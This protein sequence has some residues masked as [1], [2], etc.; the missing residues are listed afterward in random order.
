[1]K[2]I[3]KNSKIVFIGGGGLCRDFLMALTGES[4]ADLNVTILG[5]ADL[6]G[7]APGFEYAKI[8]GIKTTTDFMELIKN[9]DADLI[10][11][12]TGN[13][14]VLE[15]ISANKHERARVIDHIEALTFQHYLLIEEK[16]VELKERLAKQ[17]KDEDKAERE[18]EIFSSELQRIIQEKIKYIYEVE[19]NLKKRTANV[20]EI[21]NDLLERVKAIY[22]EEKEKYNILFDTDP[23]PI[24]IID[25]NTFKILD[26]NKRAQAYYGFSKEELLKMSFL[27]LGEDR[28]TELMDRLKDI[29]ED[30]C[31]FFSKKKHYRKDRH[32][33]YVNINVCHS[34]YLEDEAFI[35]TTTDISE[36]TEK[37]IQLIQTS[38]MTTLGTMAAGIAH[39][40]T[41]PLN[42][43][44]VGADFF[45]KKIRKGEDIDKED[46][47]TMANEINASV[48]RA[49]EI[50][51]QMRN[52][53]RQSDTGGV[54]TN[55]NTPIRDV[56]RLLRQ[57][58]RVH[59]IE[60]ELD[61]DENIP[62]IIADHNRMVQVF[63][64]L[65]INA[66]DALDEKEERSGDR[67]SV[68][69]LKIKS[70]SE[71]KHVVIQITD[72]GIGIPDKI[73]E[74]IFEPFFTTKDVGKGTGLG[75]SIS[76]SIIKDYGGTI[77]AESRENEGTTFE[78]K[79]PAT[80]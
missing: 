16:I 25:S 75:M 43:I 21:E 78:L 17:F 20:L 52:F 7:K 13:N 64:N 31:V 63:M 50:I 10:F 55:V 36:T 3:L 40:L 28:D 35:A 47:Y 61:L 80:L 24:F 60:M 12:L 57:Q 29:T 30:Q 45:L 54:K 2:E 6:N 48:Q 51:N 76:Y 62:Y 74:K 9:A 59:E 42:V 56:I 70:F 34:K 32:Q 5:V 79:F 65:V 18:F 4:F 22:E 41:Q 39:E 14:N 27:D 38:K 71:N 68:K 49:A 1:M 46:L 69:S 77:R 19:K 53:S 66:M 67:E 23:N 15:E 37:E 26:V 11:E 72:T 33:F 8:K 44:Q 58:L 73:K